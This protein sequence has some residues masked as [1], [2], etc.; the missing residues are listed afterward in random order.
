MDK[1]ITPFGVE[2]GIDDLDPLDRLEVN[3]PGA[4]LIVT[5]PKEDGWRKFTIT[6]S[7]DNVKD[8]KN[9]LNHWV[10][11]EEGRY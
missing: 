8:L 4:S 9:T 10:E 7:M 6:L 5:V 1:I 2:I 3:G 11:K